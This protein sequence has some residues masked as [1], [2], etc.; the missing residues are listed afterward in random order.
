M[1]VPPMG[2]PAGVRRDFEALEKRRMRAARLLEKGYSQSEVAAGWARTA[3]RSA[4]GRPN[5]KKRAGQG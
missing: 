5:Y 4:S 1:I 2:F 3:S